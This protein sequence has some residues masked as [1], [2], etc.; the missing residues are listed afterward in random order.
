MQKKKIVGDLDKTDNYYYYYQAMKD[1]TLNKETTS[2]TQS[3]HRRYIPCLSQVGGRNRRG[4]MRP[5][6]RL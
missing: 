4:W 5:S 3:C 2:L 6:V 1:Y